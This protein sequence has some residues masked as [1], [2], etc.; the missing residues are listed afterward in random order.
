MNSLFPREP[1]PSRPFLQGLYPFL[2]PEHALIPPNDGDTEMTLG[3]TITPEGRVEQ[4]VLVPFSRLY[5]IKAVSQLESARASSIDL[6]TGGAVAAAILL[7]VAAAEAY[8][9][10]LPLT[11]EGL[12]FLAGMDRTKAKTVASRAET[13]G[14]ESG[15]A[16]AAAERRERNLPWRKELA[17]VREL[18]NSLVH[19]EPAYRRL[20][21]WP[22]RLSR[23]NCRSFIA[24]WIDGDH[25]WT[26]QLV[27]PAVGEWSLRTIQQG[28]QRLHSFIGGAHPWTPT[29]PTW[30]WWPPPS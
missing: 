10:E 14:I 22:Q 25:D 30:W 3:G 28:I 1:S 24:G 5:W 18:R 6:E 23:C 12:P 11:A 27:V 26:S 20:G 8:I 21:E 29:L 19:F 9:A 4:R 16:A 17:C 15:I 7:G 13:K 2:Y